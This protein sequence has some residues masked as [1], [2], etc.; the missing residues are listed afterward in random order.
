[1]THRLLAPLA[2]I[3]LSAVLTACPGPSGNNIT[4]VDGLGGGALSSKLTVPGLTV[5][6]QCTLASVSATS[7]SID[8]LTVTTNVQA[9]S[10]SSAAVTTPSL[11]AE[12]ASIDSVIAI[13][14][15]VTSLALPPVVS[16]PPSAV[17]NGGV[18]GNLLGAT[19]SGGPTLATGTGYTTPND[20]CVAEFGDESPHAHVCS[21]FEVLRFARS[22]TEAIA[23]KAQAAAT[24]GG[25][26]NGASYVTMALS[27][28]GFNSSN[29]PIVAD[30]CG[31]WSTALVTT[32]DPESTHARHVLRIFSFDTNQ[33]LARPETTNDC[34]FDAI[35]FLCC[36]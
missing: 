4:S 22:G 12:A 30:D 1:M 5:E 33:F 31:G 3:I 26:L 19:S 16:E 34:S 29:A 13:E 28:V 27:V 32:P 10:V 35:R 21:D 25:D 8:E 11:S 15:T 17:D 20:A 23:L 36:G 9:A 18:L 2:V 14:A 24:A 6:G 7:A